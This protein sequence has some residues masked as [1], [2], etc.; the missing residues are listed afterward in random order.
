MDLAAALFLS[1][2][3]GDFPLQTNQIYRLKNESWVGV[4]LHAAIHV[5]L[6]ALLVKQPLVVWPMLTTL[7]ILHFLI[8]LIKLRMPSVNLS[9]FF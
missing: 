2:L 9:A 4:A 5:I 1:H 6:A 3:V 7:G 8:D